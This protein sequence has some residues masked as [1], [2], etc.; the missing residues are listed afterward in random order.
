MLIYEK[1]VTDNGETVRKLYGTEANIPGESD[2]PIIYTDAD[3]DPVDNLTQTSQLFD[4]GHGGIKRLVVGDNGDEWDKVSV[5]IKTASGDVNVI[6]GDITVALS[7]IR[8]VTKP[9][10]LTYEIDNTDP[11]NLVYPKFDTAGL[12]VKGIYSDGSLTDD[13]L[14]EGTDFT[15]TP[16]DDADLTEAG[17]KMVKVEGKAGTDYAG[18]STSFKITVTNKVTS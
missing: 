13:A 11:D 1:K 14:T 2:Y 5:W 15:T 7:G 6:P 10:T 9:T 17:S 12:V 16:A 3:G 4:D 8:V 18:F